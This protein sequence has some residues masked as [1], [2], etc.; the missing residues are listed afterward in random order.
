MISDPPQR[1]RVRSAVALL[2]SAG[3]A[4]TALA[5]STGTADAASTL[6]A[7]AAQSGRYFGAAIS[8]GHLGEAQY[9]NT[10]TAEFNGVTPENEM[11][12]DTV[13]PNRNQFNFGPADA[14]VS[15]ARSRGMAVRG[16][17]LVWHAQLGGWVSGLDASNL[18]SAMQNHISQVAGHW[19]GQIY[20][21]DV[22]NEAFEENGTRRQSVFQQKLGDG[23]IEEA[24][25]AA[26][27]ADP[28]AKLC[29]N[30]Y[31]TDGIN[32]KSTGIYNMVRDF[33]SRGVPIDCVGFQSH[34]SSNSNLSSY[35]ANLQRFADLGVDVQITELDV[36]GS[37]SGQA[38]VYRTVTQACMAVSRCTGITVWGV[39]DK[40]SWRASDTPLLFDGNYGKKQAYS[41]V[42][43]A[44]NSGGGDGGGGSGAVRA[45]AANRCL[46]VPNS[47]TTTGTQL[48]IWD[49]HSGANQQWTRTTTGELS[50]YSGDS[51]R[52]LGTSGGGTSAGTAA[53]IASCDGGGNQRW[54][55][56]GNGTITNVQSGLCLD[57]NGAATA[58]GTSVIIWTCNGGSNQQWTAP[59]ASDGGG[60]SLPS[61]Y[62]WSSSG[63]LIAPK[64][65]ATH[66]IAGI[67][68]PSVVYHNGKWHVFASVA[69]AAGYNMVYLSFTDWSQAGSATHYYLDQSGIGAGYRAAPEVF[70]FAPQGLWY[71]VYQDGNAAYSTN[72]DISNPAGWSAPKH[73]YSSM[74]QIIR[75]NIGNGYWVDMWV[76]C[77]S[78]NCHLFSSDDNGHLYRSQTTVG[79]FPNGMNDPVIAA[80]DSNRYAL[81]E[82]SNVYKVDGS[83]QYLLIVE[84]IGA[85]G[86]YFRSWTSTSIAGPWTALADA[87]SAPFAGAANVT[88][89][90]G[91][92]TRDISHGEMVRAGYD[93][94]LT[95]NPCAIR[96]LYQG[97]DPNSGG[98]Y[99]SLPWRLGLLTQTNSTC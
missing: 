94:T 5:L 53:V 41:A 75:D 92:W 81:F 29:Y 87:E 36:G 64:S 20:A 23:Y 44:L 54:N 18:R 84:A 30:D 58:N 66:N 77:D 85:Q 67:K 7:A 91:Q 48:Q 83:N 10:W 40:Y 55:V 51:R 79:N 8:R 1:R 33:K 2:A 3:L 73:F 49:C 97:R 37:G 6:G 22:V 11:K 47:S 71:L 96:Y 32:S 57:V 88:F 31:N 43:D 70:Y 21:W 93:Q 34:L 4:A 86:R 89:P 69:N 60:G 12:W 9:V 68:D 24:F 61:R 45:V 46:D 42:L 14:I 65:D 99:N 17:T 56:N 90:S 15:Q 28:N 98:D 76:I 35:Q 39:T 38:N 50:V 95:I 72:P 74:P 25:R 80:Q 63:P 78:A 19:K 13:E 16:H 26:R 62:S 59:T 27:T 82:A 52:C